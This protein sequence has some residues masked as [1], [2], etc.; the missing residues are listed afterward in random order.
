MNKADWNIRFAE[1]KYL[2]KEVEEEG[3]TEGL[4]KE[5]VQKEKYQQLWFS[6]PWTQS[7]TYMHIFVTHIEHCCKYLPYINPLNSNPTRYI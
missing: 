4:E 1:K 6:Q 3:E 2:W 7:S 5:R